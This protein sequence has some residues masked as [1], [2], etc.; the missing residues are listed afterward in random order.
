M[1]EAQKTDRKKEETNKAEDGTRP[2]TVAPNRDRSLSEAGEL[3]RK[4]EE[5]GTS[6]SQEQ[7]TGLHCKR[8]DVRI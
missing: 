1:D 4:P 2:E 3:T 8:I 7:G 5:P 6:R